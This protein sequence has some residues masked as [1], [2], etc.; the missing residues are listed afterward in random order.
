M[1]LGLQPG[2]GHGVLLSSRGGLEATAAL[3]LFGGQMTGERAAELGFAWRAVA[4]D[5]VEPCANEMAA[6]P[7]R[8]PELAR[9]TAR[10][11]RMQAGHAESWDAGLELER[12]GQMWSMYRRHIANP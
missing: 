9:G 3:A 5:E 12:A 10:A 4:D 7:A 1:R 8:D 11:I 2:G 6:A